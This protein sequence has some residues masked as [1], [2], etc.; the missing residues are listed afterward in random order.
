MKKKMV[1]IYVLIFIIF[2][3]FSYFFVGTS[4]KESASEF[5]VVFSQKHSQ[6]LGLDWKK[7]Y[8]AIL[9]DLN[10]KNIR[11]LTSWDL[12]EKEEGKY[13]F[14]D[15]DWQILNAQK[16]GAKVILV[17]GLKTGRWPECHIPQ[18][19]KSLNLKDLENK[20]LSLDKKI[21]LRYKNSNSILFWQVENEPFFSFGVCPKLSEKFVK[22][23]INLVKLL[24]DKK[25]P[26]LV[27]DSGEG[28]FWFKTAKI[29]DI[30]GTSVYKKV[31]VNQL[32]IYFTYH[33]PAV[34][35]RRKAQLIKK[36]FQ[37][38]VICTELQTEPWGPKLLYDLP[39]SEQE[40]TMNLSQFKSNI[41]FAKKIGFE[42]Y[43]LWGVE[44]WFWLKEKQNKPEIW[45]EAK[46]LF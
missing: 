46:K 23:E 22:Q 12:I 6:N 11:I 13:D 35:Y 26:V 43:Y 7:N 17:I 5:G 9:N 33:L 28:S 38:K 45:Q 18:W 19:A 39:L 8:L 42:K 15:L 24:D 1:I 2:V 37:K 21:V 41:E 4:K 29:A 30:V 10:C 44:W 16:N 3:I 34:F 36:I 25:R 31:W 27:S 14:S 20:V 40:K 32:K